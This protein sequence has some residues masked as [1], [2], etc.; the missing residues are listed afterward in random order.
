VNAHDALNVGFLNHLVPASDLER[1]TREL[2]K[3]IIENAPLA[4]KVFKEQFTLLSKGHSIDAETGERIQ[5]LRRIVYDSED[6]GEGIQAF[7]EK[8]PPRF[9]GK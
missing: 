9:K 8:R 4:V 5:S 7:H 1:F 2:A 3:K 6:Y